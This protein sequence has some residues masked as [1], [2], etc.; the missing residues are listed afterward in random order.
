MPLDPVTFLIAISTSS[1]CSADRTLDDPLITVAGK[2]FWVWS[3]KSVAD[4]VVTA[5]VVFFFPVV[6]V[7][8]GAAVVDA[9]IAANISVAAVAF[10][11]VDLVITV[12]A[13]ST[14]MTSET[15][16]AD[17][18]GFSADF[19]A[20]ALA[21]SAASAAEADI[22]AVLDAEF[23]TIAVVFVDFVT[24]A[25]ALVAPAPTELTPTTSEIAATTC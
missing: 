20:P 9:V 23:T 25:W 3:L 1:S 2:E 7:D 16:V 21:V 5:D 10:D 6:V 14:P 12:G 24:E 15:V 22:V 11:D 8:A 13:E 18:A 4:G 19:T 17:D